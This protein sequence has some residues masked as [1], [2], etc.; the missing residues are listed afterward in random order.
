MQCTPQ[1][2]ETYTLLTRSILIHEVDEN[3][4]DVENLDHRILKRAKYQFLQSE[5]VMYRF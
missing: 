2:Q 5:G 4:S 1:T 3:I